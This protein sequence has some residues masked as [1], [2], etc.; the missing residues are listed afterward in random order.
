MAE[1]ES[2]CNRPKNSKQEQ[3]EIQE[4]RERLERA[5]RRNAE[6]SEQL[7]MHK[8]H[9]KQLLLGWELKVKTSNDIITSQARERDHQL[10]EIA[11]DLL[12]FES[13]LLKHR[14][15]A[16]EKLTEKNR[17]I[18]ELQRKSKHQEK[19]INALNN[20]NER[21]LASLHEIRESYEDR[22]LDTVSGY[23]S[24][25][26]L[27]DNRDH[28]DRVQFVNGSTYNGDISGRERERE[29]SSNVS[30]EILS[31][32]QTGNPRFRNGRSR[33]RKFSDVN[34]CSHL[35]NPYEMK[36]NGIALPRSQQQISHKVRFT[37]DVKEISEEEDRDKPN[38]IVKPVLKIRKISLPAYRLPITDDEKEEYI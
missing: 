10:T 19:Q 16:K 26:T 15:K 23:D 3:E 30:L 21:L 7:K 12:Y 29:S 34:V 36:T 9:T 20:A 11:S 2:P 38:D 31:A 17:K 37:P 24:E 13:C 28:M 5:E 18:S 1:G 6:L 33:T 8:L 22:K 25:E 35:G 14:T 27:C 4:L 32:K